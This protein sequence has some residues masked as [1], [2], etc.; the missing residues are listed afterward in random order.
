MTKFRLYFDKDKETA[1]INEMVKKGYAMTGFFAGFYQ[2]EACTP[3]E[4]AYQIDFG[5]KM[6]SVSNDYHEFMEENNI[7]IVCLW[8]YWIILR[9]RT[10]DGEFVLYTD[11]DSNIEHYTKILKMF[12]AVTI[13]EL[14]CFMVEVL[15]AINGASIGFFFMILLGVITIAMM[16]ATF[17]TKR[18]IN[19]LKERKGESV[20]TGLASGNVSPFLVAGLLLN[21]CA[22]ALHNSTVSHSIVMIIQI[23]AITVM[24]IGLYKSRDIF[25]K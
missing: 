11:V 20:P 24:L 1:W 18:L 17:S 16:R 19:E 22:A 9:K 21:A 13:L 15:G 25:K 10:A 14:I 6:F 5:S 12:K 7:E 2:F 3:G 8:G 23:V 4:Y